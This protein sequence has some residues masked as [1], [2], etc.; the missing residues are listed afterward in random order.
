MDNNLENERNVFK[1]KYSYLTIIAIVLSSVSILF[2]TFALVNTRGPRHEYHMNQMSERPCQMRDNNG[3]NRPNNSQ[4]QNSRFDKPNS[5]NW[6]G[7]GSNNNNPK[8]ENGSSPNDNSVRENGPTTA[9]EISPQG[10]NPF[11]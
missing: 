3:F 7:K 4:G 9:P 2:S 8:N 11:F 5:R 10:N 1:H 6:N